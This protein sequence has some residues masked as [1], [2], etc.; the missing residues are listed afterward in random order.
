MKRRWVA[1]LSSRPTEFGELN[2]VKLSN[3]KVMEE[4][5]AILGPK[6]S[7]ESSHDSIRGALGFRDVH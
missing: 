4:N 7:H 5:L 1:I 6:Q 3:R 2:K